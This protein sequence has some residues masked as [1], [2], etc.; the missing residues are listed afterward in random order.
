MDAAGTIVPGPGLLPP[1]YPEL[2]GAVYSSCLLPSTD[3]AGELKISAQEA[4]EGTR[5]LLKQWELAALAPFQL[6]HGTALPAFDKTK[7][8]PSAEKWRLRQRMEKKEGRSFG[9][10]PC[11][12][13]WRLRYWAEFSWLLTIHR[14]RARHVQPTPKSNTK[15]CQQQR[16]GSARGRELYVTHYEWEPLLT[17]FVMSRFRF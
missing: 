5:Q 4:V 7:Q 2:R 14:P 15:G 8:P 11:R 12:Q 17:R 3:A 6:L 10:G 13:H 16:C 9:P 1:Q